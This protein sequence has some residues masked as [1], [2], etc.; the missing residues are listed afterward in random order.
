MLLDLP[1]QLI[2]PEHYEAR[3]P[4]IIR[5]EV[6]PRR[7]FPVELT[8][9]E[10]RA[11]VAELRRSGRLDK[12]MLPGMAPI[13]AGGAPPATITFAGSTA[14]A[15]SGASPRTFTD[16][17]IGPAGNRWVVVGAG[18]RVNGSISGVTI[19]GNAMTEVVANLHGSTTSTSSS[20]LWIYYYP[21]GTTAT[22]VV[23]VTGTPV[24]GAGIGV[25]AL[26]DL[27]SDTP[28]DTQTPDGTPNTASLT[29]AAGGVCVGIVQNLGSSGTRTNSWSGMSERYDNNESGWSGQS[30]ADG[31]TSGTVTCTIS[32]GVI[33]AAGAFAAFR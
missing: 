4:A 8:R 2:L 21:T 6:D 11:I 12:A 23:S 28:T 24:A 17:A 14:V 29:V 16:H 32:A 3:R 27:L 30:G 10:R 1:P 5:P 25:W 20:G 18:Q 19:T 13:I 33:S 7:Y 22:I 9:A 15:N 26:Y 31:T